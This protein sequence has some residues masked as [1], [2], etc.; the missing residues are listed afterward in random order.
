TGVHNLTPIE[1][2]RDSS[3]LGFSI[4]RSEIEIL[5]AWNHSRRA[6]RIKQEIKSGRWS[7]LGD[8]VD[9]E[10]LKW[11]MMFKRIDANPDFG[12]EVITQRPLFKLFPEGRWLSR[13]YLLNHSPRYVVPDQTILIAKQGTLGEDELYCRC[14]FITGRRMLRRAYSDHCMRVVVR[15]GAI[16]PGY[17]FAFLRSHAGFRLLR[18]LSEG[19]KQQDLHWRT[20]PTLPIP[21]CGEADEAKIGDEV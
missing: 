6:Q 3:D 16:D 13:S 15:E 4:R 8:L 19:S 12:I 11:R 21:R 20:V 5:R 7:L 10:W 17:L 9:A 2:L 14:E 1:W 18:S